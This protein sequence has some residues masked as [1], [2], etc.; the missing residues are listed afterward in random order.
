ME[1]QMTNFL[2]N[3]KKNTNFEVAGEEEPPRASLPSV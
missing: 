2:H 1:A 3:V